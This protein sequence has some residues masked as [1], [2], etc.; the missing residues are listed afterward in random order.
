M[1]ERLKYCKAA[2]E[3]HEL[4]E[5]DMVSAVRLVERRL[6]KSTTVVTTALTVPTTK[7]RGFCFQLSWIG[8]STVTTDWQTYLLGDENHKRGIASVARIF[9]RWSPLKTMSGC[10]P[11]PC[12]WYTYYQNW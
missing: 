8:D 12:N 9:L 10:R 3:E 4:K 11:I 1:L 5:V 7:K 6:P 2:N